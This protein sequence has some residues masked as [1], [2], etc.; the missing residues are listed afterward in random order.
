MDI[1]VCVVVVYGGRVVVCPG[2]VVVVI[3][4]S[5]TVVVTLGKN[6]VVVVVVSP[7]GG[8]VPVYANANDNKEMTINTSSLNCTK[9]TPYYRKYTV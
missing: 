5:G 1:G 3:P 4:G 9:P 7:G 6:V 8:S 2:S